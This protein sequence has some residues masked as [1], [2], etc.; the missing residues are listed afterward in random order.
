MNSFRFLG[1]VLITGFLI[2]AT[3]SKVGGVMV[4]GYSLL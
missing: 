1:M 4:K 2:M 3:I